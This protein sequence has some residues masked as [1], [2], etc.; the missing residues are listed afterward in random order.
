MM[1]YKELYKFD[2][3]N[4][5]DRSITVMKMT[6]SDMGVFGLAILSLVAMIFV[7]V[8]IMTFIPID[9]KL[10]PVIAT[11]FALVVYSVVFFSLCLMLSYRFIGVGYYEA[12]VKPQNIEAVETMDNNYKS[13]VE[14]KDSNNEKLKLEYRGNKLKQDDKIQVRTNNKIVSNDDPKEIEFDTKNGEDYKYLYKGKTIDEVDVGVFFN[15]L[16]K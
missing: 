5:F 4:W 10:K 14:I 8:M 13:K 6:L 9:K 2:D 3:M 11:P 15:K 7:T 1:E 12:D 16:S